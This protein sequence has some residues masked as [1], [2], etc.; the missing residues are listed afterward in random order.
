MTTLADDEQRLGELAQELGLVATAAIGPWVRGTIGRFLSP[1]QQDRFARDI[2]QAATEAEADVG[3]RLE[4]LLGTD[5]DRQTSSPLAVL[6]SVVPFAAVVLDRA[7]ICAGERDADARRLHPDDRYDLTPGS[8]ADF[9]DAV[10]SAGLSWGAG[11]AH[12][13]LRRRREEGAR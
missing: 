5:V 4:A 7:G 8:F 9:G 6:R 1:E 11:K 10:Q 3:S 13:H 2:D 12:V